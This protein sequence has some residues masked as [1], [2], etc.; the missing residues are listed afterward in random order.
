MTDLSFD[1]LKAFLSVA[2]QRSF[3]AAAARL[4][5]TTTAVSKAVK[6][7]EKRHGV[8]LFQRTTRHVALTEAGAALYASLEP[9]V[10]QI[11]AAFAA[12]HASLGRPSG[13]LR[14]TMPRALGA[15]LI[16]PLTVRFRAQ[17]PDVTLDISL[18]DR[19]VD[20]VAQGFDAGIRLGEAIAQDMVALRLSPDL[21]WSVLGS[22]DYFARMGRPATPEELTAH[23][24]LRYRFPGSEAL[25]R[26]AFQRKGRRFDV[27]TGGHL[28]VNDTTLLRAFARAGLGL[29]YLPDMEAGADIASGQLERVLQ[30]YVPT[31]GG[32]FLYFPVRTQHQ[33]KLRA[34]IEVAQQMLDQA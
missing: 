1:G 5:I 26:W 7:L 28:I 2:R 3:T 13:T 32:L 16:A 17:C 10:E 19:A 22:P 14:L 25:P 21:H 8:V 20:L 9:A 11:D 29:A 31:S 15:L 30:A 27:E 6:L 33:P 23:A 4:G 34:F 24:T 18:D 12:M